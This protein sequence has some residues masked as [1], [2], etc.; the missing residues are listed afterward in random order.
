MALPIAPGTYGID[1]NH[2]QLGFAVRHL[3][4]SIIRGTF[5]R[6]GGSLDVGDDLSTT[7]VAIEAEMASINSGNR[8]R[9]EHM[10]GADWFDVANHPQ[11]TFRS[12]SIVEAGDGYTMTGELTIRDI[13]ETVTFDAAYNGSETFPMDQSTH[14]GFGATG[15]IRRSAFGISY[16]LGMLGDDVKLNLDVQFVRP[17]ADR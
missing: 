2:S 1:T 16:G 7:V 3:G 14:F 9:D 12:S 6:Y 11:M 15:T 8:D 5:D 10:H 13:T 4:I 17:P